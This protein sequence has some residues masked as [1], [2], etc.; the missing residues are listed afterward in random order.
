MRLHREEYNALGDNTFEGSCTSHLIENLHYRATT[1]VLSEFQ[2]R[3]YPTFSEKYK[4]ASGPSLEF[5]VA[6][7][8]S[9]VSL[10]KVENL[11]DEDI[12]RRF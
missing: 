9:S 10:R 8:E 4:I 6:I 12:S 5:I 2:R 11:T 3:R 1:E 7:R